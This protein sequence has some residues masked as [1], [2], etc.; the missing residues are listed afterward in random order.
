MRTRAQFSADA[1]FAILGTLLFIFAL[2]VIVEEMNASQKE[3]AIAN[4]EL[5]IA[6][7]L[8]EIIVSGQALSDGTFSI[9][10][11]IPKLVIPGKAEKESCSIEIKDYWLKVKSDY[12]EGKSVT[13]NLETPYAN[14]PT[15]AQCGEELVIR[16]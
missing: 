15:T 12:T 14:M 13:F 6:N 16:G 11:K 3:I 9:S 8:R 2:Q 5:K 7:S 10:Y 1:M 4:Q